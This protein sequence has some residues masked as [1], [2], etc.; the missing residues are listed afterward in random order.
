M[1]PRFAARY[2]RNSSRFWRR[3][4][5]TGFD[6]RWQSNFKGAT[7]FEKLSWNATTRVCRPQN[8]IRRN[9]D[10]RR[11]SRKVWKRRTLMKNVR[12]RPYMFSFISLIVYASFVHILNHFCH[13]LVCIDWCQTENYSDSVNRGKGTRPNHVIFFISISRT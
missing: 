5:R 8:V 11:S 1:N 13:L 12:I 10:W 9:F 4:I 2:F 7:G 6:V 3:Q